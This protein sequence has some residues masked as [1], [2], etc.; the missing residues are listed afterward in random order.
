MMLRKLLKK[1]KRSASLFAITIPTLAVAQV[2]A[3]PPAND[4]HDII[5][6]ATRRDQLLSKVPISIS[7]FTQ[8]RADQLGI[9]S[10]ADVVKFTPGV[11]FD[12]AGAN[13]SGANNISIRGVSSSAGTST[14]G[15]YI[16]DTPMQ[17]RQIGLNS[18]SPLPII[19]DLDRVEV[20]RGPQGT[21]FG[22][23][24]EG[25]TVR[26]IT[27][28]PNLS[29]PSIYAR[30]EVS[31]TEKGGLSYEAG[32]ALGAPIIQDVLGFRIS[33]YYR[34]DGGY[35]DRVDPYTG[36]RTPNANSVD[37]YAIR[38]AL[39]WK[40]TPNLE[41]IPSVL[42][43]NRRNHSTEVAGYTV[44]L[45][46]PASNQFVTDTP[47]PQQ[48]S[49]HFYIAA[50]KIDYG[51]EAIKIISN[52]SYFDRKEVVNGYEGTIYD[53]SYFQHSLDPNNTAYYQLDPNLVACA[54]CN[55]GLFPL[56]N[57]KG[58]NPAF[59]AA[60]KALTGAYYRSP[61]VITNAQQ[62][63]TQEVRI[64]SNARDSKW[65]W[66]AGVFYSHINQDSDETIIDPNLNAVSQLL[67]GEDILTAWTVPLLPGGISYENHGTTKEWQLAGFADITFSPTDK[68]K[69]N[70]GVRY[71]KTHF[72]IS[73]ITQGPEAFVNGP[74]P[75]A[76][77]KDDTPLTPKFNIAYQLTP[78]DLLYATV[79]KG[80]RAA[81]GNS[82]LLAVCGVPYAPLTY[83][84][85]SL[86]NYEAGTKLK[87]FGGKL[88]VGASAYL[89]KWSNIQQSVYVTS[90]GQQFVANLGALTSKGFDF[91]A[92]AHLT[93][94][95]EFDLAVG[96]T[97]ARYTKNSLLPDPTGVSQPFL[98]AFAGDTVAGSPWTIS[99]GLQQDFTV[100]GHKA[101]IRIDDEYGSHNRANTPQTDAQTTTAYGSALGTLSYDGRLQTDPA[102]NQ[103]SMRAGIALGRID[104]A[105]FVNNLFN[106][107]P[108]LGLAHQ[109]QTS[110]LF[111]ASTLRPRTFGLFVSYRY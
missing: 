37:S 26:F 39:G 90:C 36:A 74:A 48:D 43:Q 97:H 83:D 63:F 87:L 73:N 16:D 111:T 84:S 9:K 41:I 88:R 42:Y 2:A 17:V 110:D 21:L 10:F 46:N 18:N 56:L 68:L 94:S 108:Q 19:F 78:S 52:T 29:K 50:L 45:S 38:A 86:W 80:Y 103:A 105:V 72:E 8:S 71:A 33:S 109:D 58:I 23:G 32:V 5:V 40:P 65:N 102:T 34:R 47:S 61:N 24:S 99:A 62:N 15:L 25:G 11:S 30:S 77:S 6:T 70:V 107:H 54:N 76:S 96:Y 51:N 53:L 89:I 67:F 59:A 49:D 66:V 91:Q 82:P 79:S 75:R 27:P 92:E 31:S 81:G 20:L 14:T 44:G 104:T 13:N 28:S 64:Q 95:L 106:A 35:I 93:R 101:F 85:D 3:P 12:A 98:L 7:A 60:F 22:A 69:L 100:G 55:Y 1:F 57:S 4:S